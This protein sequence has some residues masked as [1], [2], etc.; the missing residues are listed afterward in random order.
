MHGVAL[1][2]GIRQSFSREDSQQHK[3]DAVSDYG[4]SD[5]RI[6]IGRVW[7]LIGTLQKHKVPRLR[8][9]SQKN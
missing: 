4:W 6:R 7:Q 1:W 5:E 8:M 9:I 3:D 2:Q